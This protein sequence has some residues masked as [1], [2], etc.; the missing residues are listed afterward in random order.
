MRLTIPE[1]FAF[2][3]YMWGLFLSPSSV[4]SHFPADL[5]F[6]YVMLLLLSPYN[7]QTD[8]LSWYFL[9]ALVNPRAWNWPG[10]L[11]LMYLARVGPTPWLH[12]YIHTYVQLHHGPSAS[13]GAIVWWAVITMLITQGQSD[14][15]QISNTSLWPIPQSW[16]TDKIRHKINKILYPY[17]AGAN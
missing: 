4:S 15:S 16:D 3:S 10:K 9:E 5:S 2:S 13:S 12:T 1:I 6:P 17:W 8:V 14:N 7:Q 11:L